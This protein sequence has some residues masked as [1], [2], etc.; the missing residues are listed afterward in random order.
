MKIQ[1]RYDFIDLQL[2][3]DIRTDTK[4]EL[5]MKIADEIDRTSPTNSKISNDTQAN[6]LL[7]EKFTFSRLL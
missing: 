1:P 7:P 3:H 4:R 6:K 5:A 2:R